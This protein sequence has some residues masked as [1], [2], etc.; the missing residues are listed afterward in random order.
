MSLAEL[1]DL[2][3]ALSC[4]NAGFASLGT[5]GALTSARDSS[6]RSPTV[7]RLGGSW[8]PDQEKPW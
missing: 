1:L 3:A 4:L 6:Q 5:V 8:Q 7:N 2:K